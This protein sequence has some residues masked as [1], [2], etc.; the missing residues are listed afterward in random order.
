[1]ANKNQ[2]GN[3]KERPDAAERYYDLKTS[4]MDDLTNAKPGKTKS[5]SM[6]ELSKYRRTKGI[7]MADWLKI[8]LIKAWFA[9]AICY[10]FF[11]GLGA[12]LHS[13]IDMMFIVGMVLGFAT[14]LLTNN[15]IRF[16][17]VTPGANDRWMMFPKKRYLSLVLNVLYSY[18]I[19]FCVYSTYT[20]FNAAVSVM[21]G[22]PD[23]VT[24]GVEPLLFGILCMAFDL[25]F[26]WM[27]NTAKKVVQDA[28]DKVEGKK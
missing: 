15:L 28:R 5:Y 6:Q 25:L 3:I 20:G 11:W 18:F 23:L 17:E 21:A 7:H 19:L 4:A 13:L 9:G 16:F 12:Y 8:V 24:V 22:K 10:F 14:D 27:K 26:V 2:T 1:M